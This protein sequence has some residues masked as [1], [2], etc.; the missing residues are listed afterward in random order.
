MKKDKSCTAILCHGPGHFSKTRCYKT[1]KHTTHAAYYGSYEQH[2]EWLGDK[3][4]TGF[5]DDPKE[6]D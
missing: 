4:F 2:M 3:A 6:I 5:F 1:G